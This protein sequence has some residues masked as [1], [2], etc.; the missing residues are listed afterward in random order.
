MEGSSTREDTITGSPLAPCG[1][2]WWNDDTSRKAVHY[3]R[4]SRLEGYS[5]TL[6]REL[7]R[8]LYKLLYYITNITE[9]NETKLY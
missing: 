8:Q 6:H 4:R 7:S 5:G 3:L 2:S 9:H 1:S